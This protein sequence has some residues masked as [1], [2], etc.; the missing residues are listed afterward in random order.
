MLINVPTETTDT[1]NSLLD[2]I[3]ANEMRSDKLKFGVMK[4]EFSDHDLTF[5]LIKSTTAQPK[6]THD[7]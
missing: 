1:T 6:E 7:T 2:H 5:A 4:C 3:Y